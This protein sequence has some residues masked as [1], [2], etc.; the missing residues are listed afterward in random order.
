[1]HIL[2]QRWL[3]RQLLNIH[4]WHSATAIGWSIIFINDLGLLLGNH[5]RAGVTPSPW[6]TETVSVDAVGHRDGVLQA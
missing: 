4:V 2:L 3:K 1:M 6:P 5:T